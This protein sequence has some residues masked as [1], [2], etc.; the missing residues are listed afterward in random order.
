[1]SAR[2]GPAGGPGPGASPVARLPGPVVFLLLSVAGALLTVTAM[3][4]VGLDWFYCHD[5]PGASPATSPIHAMSVL[6]TMWSALTRAAPRGTLFLLLIQALPY[7]GFALV[8]GFS[9]SR[10]RRAAALVL[11]ALLALALFLPYFDPA[12]RYGCGHDLGLPIL[13]FLA[14]LGT[15]PLALALLLLPARPD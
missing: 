5:T 7:A 11:W 1:M 6:D 15:W 2:P 8:A 14:F 13:A 4:R 12:D 3:E 10:R 9:R